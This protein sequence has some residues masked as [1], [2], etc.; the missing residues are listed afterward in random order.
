MVL[1]IAC[2]KRKSKLPRCK[3]IDMYQGAMFRAAVNLAVKNNWSVMILSAKYGF[4]PP[5]EDIENYDCKATNP[6]TG[7]W[8][9]GRGYYVGG[10]TYFK[11]APARFKALVPILGDEPRKIGPWIR[12]INKLLNN[13]TG[14]FYD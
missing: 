3:A 7:E 4:I 14:L 1:L 12:G 2:S 11:Y 6:Y 5:D 10:L 8:P 9:A 13:K